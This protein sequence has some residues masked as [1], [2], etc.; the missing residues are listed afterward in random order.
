[1][2]A[3]MKRLENTVQGL[4]LAGGNKGCGGLMGT[5]PKGKESGSPKIDRYTLE[6]GLISHHF[7]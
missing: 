6:E 7:R 2:L 5:S 4:A 1:M 3:K